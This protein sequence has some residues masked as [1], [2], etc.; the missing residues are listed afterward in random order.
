M[1]D[2]IRPPELTQSDEPTGEPDADVQAMKS[3]MSKMKKVFAQMDKVTV[4]VPEDVFVQVNGYPFF[5]KGRTNV[6][7]P[8]TV[9]EILEQSG[10]Y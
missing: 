1:T 10:R 2:E 5:I 4:R 9:A 6:R 8:Q 3:R 7:V